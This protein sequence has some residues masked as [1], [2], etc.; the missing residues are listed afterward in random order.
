MLST[1][2]VPIDAGGVVLLGFPFPRGAADT[3]IEECAS[4]EGREGRLLSGGFDDSLR[5]ALGLG[6]WILLQDG[7][8]GSFGA[9]TNM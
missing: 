9:S 8:E 6:V 1:V 3:D 4:T 7:L 5:R 2:D